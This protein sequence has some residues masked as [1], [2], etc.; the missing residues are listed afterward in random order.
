MSCLLCKKMV[1]ALFT[2]TKYLTWWF[3]KPLVSLFCVT[4]LTHM[5]RTSSSNQTHVLVASNNISLSCL[6]G[7]KYIIYLLNPFPIILIIWR[8]RWKKGVRYFTQNRTLSKTLQISHAVL[9]R[10][11]KQ[12]SACFFPEACFLFEILHMRKNT[13]FRRHPLGTFC[14][15]KNKRHLLFR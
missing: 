14:W 15:M 8:V 10:S 5:L 7:R 4:N 1:K 11:L 9:F 13:F 12:C 2:L 6:E 3:I